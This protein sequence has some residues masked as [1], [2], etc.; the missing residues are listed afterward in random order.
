MAS[1]NNM[2]IT[3]PA[4]PQKVQVLAS[5]TSVDGWVVAY[6]AAFA[7]RY[8]ISIVWNETTIAALI[9]L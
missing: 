7:V 1:G 8:T 3:T 2:T 9:I 6:E 5:A 4:V